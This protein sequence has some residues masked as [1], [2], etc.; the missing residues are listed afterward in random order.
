MMM[1]R[2]AFLLMRLRCFLLRRG[3]A[4]LL[5]VRASVDGDRRVG[6]SSET[7]ERST[8]RRQVHLLSIDRT[9]QNRTFLEWKNMTLKTSN[10]VKQRSLLN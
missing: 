2:M 5:G 8:E 10:Y 3:T 6:P 9:E 1:A 7:T 4:G